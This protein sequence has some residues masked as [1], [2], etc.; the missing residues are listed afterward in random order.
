MDV[1]IHI[2]KRTCVYVCVCELGTDR[3]SALRMAS[4]QLYIHLLELPSRLDS[5]INKT[6]VSILQLIHKINYLKS[7]FPAKLGN[8]LLPLPDSPTPPSSPK[9]HNNNINN[10]IFQSPKSPPKSP[11]AGEM[12]RM[13][14]SSP[15]GLVNAGGGGGGFFGGSSRS[16]A[17]NLNN[18]NENENFSEFEVFNFQNSW[19]EGE[20]Y[21]YIYIYACCIYVH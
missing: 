15:R 10:E 21:I 13:M 4:L 18:L 2:Y 1:Y 6:Q 16:S 12:A 9:N 5:R 8:S 14:V 11:T 3:K 19:N 20:V 17:G 7:C